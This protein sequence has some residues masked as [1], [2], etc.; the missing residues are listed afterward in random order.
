MEENGINKKDIPEETPFTLSLDLY[1]SERYYEVKG[2]AWFSCPEKDKGW[3]SAHSWCVIDLK[4]QII[5]FSY[6]QDC[7]RCES[8]ANPKFPDESLE[9]MAQYA[10][11]KY[12]IKTGELAAVFNP[13]IE[14]TR[15]DPERGPH[16]EMRCSK[17]RA[18]GYTCM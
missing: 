18:L 4:K 2:F 12:K 15:G 13:R 9:K 3:P 16:D 7:N 8:E 11:K 6:T 17:C 10:V 1:R 5:C 14:E